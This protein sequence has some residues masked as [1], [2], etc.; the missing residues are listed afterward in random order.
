[1]C[2]LSRHAIEREKTLQLHKNL[3]HVT[4]RVQ[5]A[6]RGVQSEFEAFQERYKQNTDDIKHST[7]QFRKFVQDAREQAQQEREQ[8]KKE[9]R[10][11]QVELKAVHSLMGELST[12]NARFDNA[13]D[14]SI[15]RALAAIKEGQT[16]VLSSISTELETFYRGLKMEG[17]QLAAFLNEEIQQHHA[18]ALLALQIEHG[19]MMQSY[20]IMGDAF[21]DAKLKVDDVNLK[22]DVLDNKTDESIAKI[23]LLDYRLN[24]L[25]TR[26]KTVERAFAAFES[27]FNIGS[28]CIVVI[29]MIL[30]ICAL[31]IAAKL[32]PARYVLALSAVCGLIYLIDAYRPL[33]NVRSPKEFLAIEPPSSFLSYLQRS[34]GICAV[35]AV[36]CLLLAAFLPKINSFCEDSR[37]AMAALP[38]AV[39]CKLFRKRTMGKSTLVSSPRLPSHRVHVLQE[40]KFDSPMRQTT[41]RLWNLALNE[42]EDQ[43]LQTRVNSFQRAQSVA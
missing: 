6:L 23:N 32:F 29:A 30:G 21:D 16:D 39:Y 26:F 1:M 24:G 18:K 19:T 5:A 41:R 38:A 12:Y 42:E 7:D 34:K 31:C 33:Q 17:S 11:V 8:V 35:I 9:V 43:A 27:L 36:V 37:D 2:Q 4:F 3:T 25:G 40:T 10:T 28:I 15:T 13:I 14:V 20:A 22:V